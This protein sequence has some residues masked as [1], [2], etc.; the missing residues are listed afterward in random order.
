MS[1]GAVDRPG[2]HDRGAE[3]ARGLVDLRLRQVER[4]LALDRPAGH[5]VAGH[6]AEQ[7]AGGVEHEAELGLRH[8]P[9][10]VG[11]DADGLAGRR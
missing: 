3:R 5:V 1:N 11:A 7:L 9:V 4:V 10:G 6:V 8:V 2:G